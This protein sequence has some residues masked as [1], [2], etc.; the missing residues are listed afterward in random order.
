MVVL[1]SS[2]TSPVARCPA[3]GP[4]KISAAKEATPSTS[5]SAESTPVWTFVTIG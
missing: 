1:I 2:R 5:R 3:R 4:E